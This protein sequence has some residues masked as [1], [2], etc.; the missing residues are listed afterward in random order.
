MPFS[1]AQ[2]LVYYRSWIV[3]VVNAVIT[4]IILIIAPLGLFAVITCTLG[5]FLSSLMVGW[6]CDRA[7]FRLLRAYNRDAMASR[8]NSVTFDTS[9]NNQLDSDFDPIRR[10]RE[11]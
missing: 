7:L 2:Q 10:R 3:A 5:V 11:N 9:V 4:W 6:V 8:Q 1:I